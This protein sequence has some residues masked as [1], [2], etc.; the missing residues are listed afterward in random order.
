[1]IWT[2]QITYEW[3]I[4]LTSKWALLSFICHW[5]LI[6]RAAEDHTGSQRF[7]IYLVAFSK[8]CRG[9][10]LTS[11]WFAEYRLQLRA[12]CIPSI[13]SYLTWANEYVKK[14]VKTL[15]VVNFRPF[16]MFWNL[17]NDLKLSYA[18]K[19]KKHLS[20]I[21]LIFKTADNC[22]RLVPIHSCRLILWEELKHLLSFL[23][24]TWDRLKR[25]VYN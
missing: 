7:F 20:F 3:N 17:A 2:K 14:L 24:T 13:P 22:E 1:M 12:Y 10:T 23:I 19:T 6:G 16:S 18:G 11:I 5:Y 8:K 25:K 15:V 4:I 9:V 21:T